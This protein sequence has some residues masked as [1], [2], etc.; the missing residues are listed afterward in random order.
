MKR[1]LLCLF[2][3]AALLLCGCSPSPENIIQLP[4]KQHTVGVLLKAM[5]SQH[6][7]DMQS[8]IQD[9]AQDLNIATIILYPENETSVRQQ[10]AMFMDLLK[11]KPDAILWAP[12]DSTRCSEFVELAKREGINV[13]ALD[14]RPEDVVLPFIGADNRNIGKLAAER[15]IHLTGGKGK[16]A[17]IS[18]SAMQSSHTERISG[19]QDALKN[20]ELSIVAIENADSD[21]RLSM[22]KT[23]LLMEAYPDLSSVF[24][25][26]AVMGLGAVEQSRATFGG[27]LSIVAVDTQDDAL[28]AVQNGTLHGLVTQSGYE[29]GYTALRVVGRALGGGEVPMDTYIRSELV[30][31]NNVSEYLKGYLRQ[32]DGQ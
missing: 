15:I 19:F 24:C 6:W 28:T 3:S 21:Y 20:T 18:G 31:R 7:R 30:T 26:S 16:V 12:C 9:A 23:R 2:A 8:G 5:N 14:T 13:Y 22:E 4:Q 1:I 11:S 25:T 10:E 32:G 29:A 17:I 27:P